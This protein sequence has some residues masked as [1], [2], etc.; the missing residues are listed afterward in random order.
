MKSGIHHDV[1]TL[2][3]GYFRP[4]SADHGYKTCWSNRIQSVART[5]T[6]DW[7]DQMQIGGQVACNF[8]SMSHQHRSSRFFA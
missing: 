4:F 1:T 5:N 8:A 7:S 3:T 6:N 2:P